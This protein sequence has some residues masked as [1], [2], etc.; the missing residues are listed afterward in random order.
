M[1]RSS[2]FKIKIDFEKSQGSYLFDKSSGK[3]YLD[4]FGQYATLA[5]RYNHPI[6]QSGDYQ[7]EVKRVSHQ[8]ITNCEILADESAEFDKIFK[9]Y[10]S[11]GIFN[12]YHYSC[13]GALAIEAAIKTA[14]HYKGIYNPRVIS[15]KGSFHGINSYGGIVTDRF[16]PVNQRLISFPG[17]YWEPLD[18][19]VIEYR[20]GEI[21]IDEEKV[22]NVLQQIEDIIVRDKNVCGILVEPIQCTYGD[23][24]FSQSFFIGIRE[25][26]DR[27]DIPLIFDEIQ[28][29]FGGTGKVWYFQHLPIVPDI[30]VFG[31]KTQLSGIMVQDKFAKIFQKSIRLEVTWDADLMDMI[32]CKYVINAYQKYN[33][34]DNVRLMSGRLVSGLKGIDRLLN[35]RNAGLLV[36]F[37]FKEKLQRDSFM[38]SLVNNEMLCNPT[39]DYTIRLRPNLCVTSAEVDHALEIMTNAAKSL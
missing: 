34:L 3:Q 6:F 26:A 2:I 16:E 37:D 12:Y 33:V 5:L 9:D 13:T 22:N 38:K 39:R 14:M 21:L 24:Y 32:R 15:F 4:F 10:T 31:K 11:I 36:A 7:S 19:P 30:V 23:R 20:D 27:Y 17:S 35:I 18:N 25:L 28:V 8:K 1:N 29:G